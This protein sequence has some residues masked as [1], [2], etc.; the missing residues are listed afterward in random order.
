V[1]SRYKRMQRGTITTARLHLEAVTFLR[2]RFKT[3]MPTLNYKP[4]VDW[5]P[6]HI[7]DLIKCISRAGKTM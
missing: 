5:Q 7:S 4:G 2:A 1:E 3:A 6:H